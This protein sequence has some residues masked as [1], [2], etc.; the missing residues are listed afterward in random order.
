M[1]QFPA[2]S[3]LGLILGLTGAAHASNLVSDGNFSSPYG[4]AVFVTDFSG[5][6]FGPWSVTS[7]SVDL[8]GGYWQSPS[9]PGG[10]SVDLDG[11]SPG[12]I[13]RSLAT[14]TGTYTLT[15]DLSGNPD[16]GPA[17]KTLDVS[18]GGVTKVFT[19]TI[20]SNT[21]ADMDYKP[22]SLTFT[23]SGPTTLSFA[24]GDVGSPYGPVVGAVSVTAVPEPASW[25]L[26]ILGAGAVGASI[27]RRQAGVAA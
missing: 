15:F 8:I 5:S 4:G 9:G 21:H 22:E 7:G 1:R 26:M 13:S 25:A 14:G 27:R 6:S 10:G 24:S 11:D 19:Y 12:A 17:T 16:G 23:A 20:G 2:L 18:V 3:A